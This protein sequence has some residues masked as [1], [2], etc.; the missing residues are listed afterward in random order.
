METRTPSRYCTARTSPTSFTNQYESLTSSNTIF[1]KGQTAT[2]LACDHDVTVPRLN[3][4][5]RAR[6]LTTSHQLCCSRHLNSTRLHGGITSRIVLLCNLYQSAIFYLQICTAAQCATVH[7]RKYKMAV[8]FIQSTLR[9]QYGGPYHYN[10]S[11]IFYL[12]TCTAA[13]CATIHIRKYKPNPIHFNIYIRH[14]PIPNL[15]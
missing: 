11:A 15:G 14:Q 12:Q 3:K 5:V 13:Q 7:I 6:H 9:R 8:V 10:P 1:G 2:I 4:S